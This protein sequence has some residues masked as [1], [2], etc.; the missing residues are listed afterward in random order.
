M[1]RDW[2]V[3]LSNSLKVIS[4]HIGLKPSELHPIEWIGSPRTERERLCCE[5]VQPHSHAWH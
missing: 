4:S 3:L 5:S 1:P 2:N